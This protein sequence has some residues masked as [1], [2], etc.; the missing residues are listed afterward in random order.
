[1]S[2][3]RYGDYRFD[4]YFD[5]VQGRMP[6]YPVDFASLERTA[7]EVLPA[8]F[9]SG[10]RSGCDGAVS[11]IRALLAEPDLLMAIDGF[12]TIADLRAAG[13]QRV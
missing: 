9:E 11:Q 3:S 5:G 7:A 8:L 13:A 10:V 12:P 6:K 2:I 1:M 4:V